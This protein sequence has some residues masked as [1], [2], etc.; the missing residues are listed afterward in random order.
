MGGC[1]PYGFVY[2]YIYKMCCLKKIIYTI[3]LNPLIR[4][5]FCASPTW[6]VEVAVW[7]KRTRRRLKKLILGEDNARKAM[8]LGVFQF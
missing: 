1:H 3:K 4:S 5:W 8:V 7:F 2:I 6:G